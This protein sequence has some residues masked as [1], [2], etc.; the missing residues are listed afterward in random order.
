[1]SISENLKNIRLE[2]N[3]TQ[4]QL[5]ERINI[6]Q[7]TIACYENGQREP[8]ISSLIAYA[9]YFECTIDYLVGRSDEFGNIQIGTE[10]NVIC[11]TTEERELINKYRNLNKTNKYIM[12]GYIDGL[13]D[14]S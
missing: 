4:K 1:M 7:A 12:K 9:N 10:N 2:H 14:K 13:N 6:A 11:V 5:S 8:H 3:L